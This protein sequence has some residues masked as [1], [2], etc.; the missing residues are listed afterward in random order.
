MI[1]RLERSRRYCFTSWSNRRRR[2]D[3]EE[4]ETPSSEDIANVRTTMLQDRMTEKEY[5]E[6]I[7]P[8]ESGATTKSSSA[9]PNHEGGTCSTRKDK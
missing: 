1:S 2:E 7:A 9:R 8:F 6:P 3:E 4:K 5:L